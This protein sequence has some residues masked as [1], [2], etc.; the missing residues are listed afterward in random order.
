MSKD[1]DN[2]TLALIAPETQHGEH[3]NAITA[4]QRGMVIPGDVVNKATQDLPDDQR[5]AIRGMHAYAVDNN[6]S[7]AEVG[8][9]LKLS[10]ATVSLVFRGK[11][12]GGVANVAKEM[13]SFLELMERRQQGR[14]LAFVKTELYLAEI[15]PI[16]TAAVDFQKIAYLFGDYQIGKSECLKY[17]QKTHN[18]GSTIYVEMPT[19]GA[20]CYFLAKLAEALRIGSQSRE[21]DLRRRILES[22]DDRML[23]IVD[24]ADRAIPDKSQGIPKSAIK[25]FD[26]ISELF[27]ERRCGVV[28]CGN[29]ELRKALTEGSVALMKK[30]WRR[31]LCAKALPAQ[32]S[33]KDLNTFASQWGLPPSAGAARELEK[34]IIEDEALGVWLTT[35]RMASVLA[36]KRNQPMKWDHVHLADNALRAMAKSSPGAE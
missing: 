18:H 3:A 9:L 19:G 27:N 28:I 6:L 29:E 7:N 24:E 35:L 20:L 10:D 8:K 14:A 32:P 21:V 31:R 22:F 30:T 12:A 26:F 5:S 34:R 13:K 15:E 1:T 36:K 25:C 17:Y 33:R 4:M 2:K 16:C 23:L 11:Y